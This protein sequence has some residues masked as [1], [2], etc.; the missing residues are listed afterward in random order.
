M[1]LS[2]TLTT[3]LTTTL[4]TT[5]TTTLPTPLPINTHHHTTHHSP[6][7]RHVYLHFINVA[8][9]SLIAKFVQCCK[10]WRWQARSTKHTN[11]TQG[12]NFRNKSMR[13]YRH[14]EKRTANVVF[15]ALTTHTVTV[16]A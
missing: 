7:P 13:E 5:L 14:Q 2:T 15:G 9:S 11:F 4:P 6:S 1:L 16:Y 3:T 12:G 8:F 10:F